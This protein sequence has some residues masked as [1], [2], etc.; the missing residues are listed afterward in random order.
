[1]QSK[2]LS[3]AALLVA[4]TTG[5]ATAQNDECSTALNLPLGVPTAFDT[6]GATLSPEVW[7]CAA[8][9]GPDLWYNVTAVASGILTVQ[10]CGSAYDTALEIFD[11]ACGA[12]VSVACN[13]DACGLQSS[14]TFAGAVAG[15]TSRVRVGGWNNN[16]GTG[17]ILA[18]QPTTPANDE[19]AAAIALTTGV[20]AAFDTTAATQSSPVVSCVAGT[21]GDVWFTYTATSNNN[22]DIATCG[23]GYDTTL[24]VFTGACNSL[25]SIACNDDAC[26]LQSRVTFPGTAG[27]TYRILVGGFGAGAGTGTIIATEITPPPANCVET[28]YANNNGGN[29][30]GAVYFDLTVTQ[31]VTLTGLDTHYSAAVGTLVG[32]EVYTVA[33]TYLGN[34]GNQ[35]AWTLAASDNGQA[36]SNGVGTPTSITFAA[37][38]NLTPG[39]YGIALVAVGS[40]HAYTNGTGTN[41][42]FVSGNGVLSLSL[43]AASNFPFLTP[44]FSPRVWNGKFCTS[45]PVGVGTNYCTAN[46]NSTG[47]TGLIS[48]SGSASIAANNLTVEASRLPNNAFGFFITSLTQGNTPNPGGSAGVLCLGGQIGRYV[49]P[50]QIKNTGSTGA[51][52]LLLNLNSIPTP[53]GSVPAVVGQTRNFQAWHR[54]VS[55]GTAT[56]NFTNGLAVTFQN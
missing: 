6:T 31:P 30:G 44:T 22:I 53:S 17:T 37:P 51:F 9:G 23:S 54:D 4:G 14:I 11:G 46:N 3:I 48:G 28:T 35:A 2:T 15:T 45:G 49:G 21:G 27:T 41:Q 25:S 40:A 13:D 20:A 10:T 1:M 56:S 43:G 50:G 8:A 39:T 42:N 5:L 38:L 55:G 29:I 33:N 16:V 26:G 36:S 34:E 24:E 19:C 18:S 32:V 7:P 52:E 12:A 47:Q